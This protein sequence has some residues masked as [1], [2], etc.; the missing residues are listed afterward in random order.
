MKSAIMFKIVIYTVLL[1]LIGL[2]SCCP[3]KHIESSINNDHKDSSW[4]KTEIKWKDSVYNTPVDSAAIKAMV[5]CPPSGVINTPVFIKKSKQATNTAAIVNNQLIAKC[6]CDGLE[7]L[8]KQ[9][10]LLQ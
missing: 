5:I 6:K 2:S 4:T 9:K 8:L 7:L 1:T 3:C 10:R